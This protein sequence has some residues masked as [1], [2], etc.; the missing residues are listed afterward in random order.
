MR[1]NFNSIESAHRTL[2]EI[3]EWNAMHLLGEFENELH[4]GNR[5]GL[6]REFAQRTVSE[7]RC[8]KQI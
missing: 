7:I 6:P 4:P 1:V 2:S 8:R 5:M 3:R